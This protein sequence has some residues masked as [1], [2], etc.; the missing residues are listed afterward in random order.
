MTGDF[1]LS[2]ARLVEHRDPRLASGVKVHGADAGSPDHHHT[3]TQSVDQRRRQRLRCYDDGVC[4]SCG[5]GDKSR[6]VD[7]LVTDRRPA[8]ERID[9]AGRI[10]EGA[11]PDYH[12]WLIDHTSPPV[13][14]FLSSGRAPRFCS[15]HW[16]PAER[17]LGVPKIDSAGFEVLDEEE[18]YALLG[19]V[20]LG[21]VAVTMDAT[22]AILPVNYALI[23]RQVVFA[24]GLGSKLTAALMSSVVA[25]EADGVDEAS[26]AAWSV[27]GHGSSMV[28]EPGS[29]LEADALLAVRSL[30]PLPRHFLA[31][32]RL[33][34][35]SGRRLPVVRPQ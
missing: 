9:N 16:P 3:A 26:G 22:P 2:V 5:R 7:S 24:T 32:V 11:N 14:P 30:A 1:Q 13:P 17:L 35:I 6:R 29:D 20:S 21:R 25:F 23:D 10:P 27:Q 28:L 15:G 34:R 31:K 8:A 18:C 4:V 12:D 19:S 33:R